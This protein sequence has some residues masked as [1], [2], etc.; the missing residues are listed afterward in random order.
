MPRRRSR[1]GLLP[2][3]TRQ[4]AAAQFDPLIDESIDDRQ[5]FFDRRLLST[6]R[7]PTDGPLDLFAEDLP[8]ATQRIDG[9]A[10]SRALRAVSLGDER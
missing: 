7:A 6:L 8:F 9:P 5:A 2:Q 3:R 4:R 10:E 1:A